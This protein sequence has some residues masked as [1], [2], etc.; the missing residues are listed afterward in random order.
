VLAADAESIAK[1]HNIQCME[2]AAKTGVNIR[3]GRDSNSP[4]SQ[5]GRRC[6]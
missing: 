3:K 4:S 6:H 2:T 1:P 5:F